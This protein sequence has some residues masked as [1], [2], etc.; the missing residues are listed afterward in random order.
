M[1]EELRLFELIKEMNWNLLGTLIIV[2]SVV[3]WVGDVVGMK[4]GKKRITFLS[5]RPKH[6]SRIISVM[7]GIGIA[8]FTLFAI[9]IAS[10]PVR[11]ALFS[12]NYVQNQITSLT[13]ELQKNRSSLQGM[14][15]ELFASKDDL[16]DKQVELQNV[17]K[18]L[19]AGTKKLKEANAQL[20]TMRLQVAKTEEKQAN[21]LKENAKIVQE[22]KNLNMSIRTLKDEAEKLKGGIQKLREGRIA[23]LT[24]ELVAQGVIQEPSVSSYQAEQFIS[25]LSDEVC[26]MM[27]YR[28]GK[29]KEDIPLPVLDDVSYAEVKTLITKNKGR[30]L[31]RMMS[32]SN[33]VEGEPVKITLQAYKTKLI[34][35]AEETLYETHIPA[36]SPRNVVEEIV[37]KSLKMLN[38]DAV[39]KGVLRDPLTGNVG[40]IDTAEFMDY[41][42][43]VT[44]SSTDKKLK[45]VAAGDI[46]TEGPVKV[47][48]ILK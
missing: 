27:A 42:E 22:S 46:Y 25:R 7:T 16:E 43:G 38:A 20:D 5:L 13:A 2:S 26:A 44:L 12:M 41:I 18:K 21:L 1:G 29:K 45:I 4:L 28:F 9:S 24:G 31:V 15:L 37:F 17:E 11:T 33:A 48:L 47:K 32:S 40:S 19:A 35:K 14:E 34:F 39:R 36:Q 23:V 3:A 10:E 6:T 8:I 30:W